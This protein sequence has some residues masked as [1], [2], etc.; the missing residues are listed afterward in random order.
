LT[1]SWPLSRWRPWPR[2]LPTRLNQTHPCA[3]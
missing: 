3:G 1:L 2:R